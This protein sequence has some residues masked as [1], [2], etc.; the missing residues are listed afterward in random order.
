MPASRFEQRR[1]AAAV[2]ADEADAR[3]GRD[4]EVEV[5]DERAA[6]ERL[7][8]SARDEQLARPARRG[9]ELD[10]GG[11]AGGPRP[12][13][14]ELLDEAARLLDASLRL[15]GARLRAPPQPLDLAPDGVG[16]RLLVGGLPA[17]E[18]VAA[19]EELAVP[20]VGLEEAVR[21]GAVQL[22]HARGHVLEEVAV[23]ADDE[24]GAR[25]LGE[26]ALQPEDAIHVEVVGGLVHQQHVGRARQLA[27]DRQALLPAAGQR[28]RPP[29]ARP[30]SRRGRASARCARG[31][32]PPPRWPGRRRRTS[33]TVPPG[34][35]TGSCGNVADADAAADGAGAAVGRLDP[36]EDLEEG[37]LAGAVRPHEAHLVSVEETERQLVEERPGPVG[38]ADRLAAQEQRP[39][40]LRATA[41]LGGFTLHHC[42]GPG[43]P[44]CPI[45]RVEG[46]RYNRTRRGER[47]DGSTGLAPARNTSRLA[48]ATCSIRA[49][50]ASAPSS[51]S[52]TSG[53]PHREGARRERFSAP[54]RSRGA[55]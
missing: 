18:L 37:G 13:V 39:G 19:G 35:K 50:A 7:R 27:R 3:A 43:R 11:A 4:G 9:Q 17:Q 22:Q 31:A 28:A 29:H 25:P 42:T 44:M 14:A 45:G 15:G 34:W 26:N 1:L 2:R 30:R 21:V 33:S 54:R 49:V 32:R 5:A 53:R 41:P 36:G 24:D 12:G 10:A 38:L 51:T 52:S 47:I 48:S 46:E 20:P 40:H 8:Q 6:A 16:E 23:V 55:G